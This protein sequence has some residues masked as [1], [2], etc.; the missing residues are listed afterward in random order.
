[1]K[2]FLILLFPLALS[3]KQDKCFPP[4]VKITSSS[5]LFEGDTLKLNASS[6]A[7][8]SF[9]WT[10]PNNFSSSLQAPFIPNANSINS[11][12]YRVTAKI[13]SCEKTETVNVNVLA[14]P[15]CTPQNNSTTF[16]SLMQFSGGVTCE[17]GT[18]AGTYELRGGGL[19]GN[20]LIKFFTDPHLKGNYVYDIS[21]MNTQSY[22]V[23]IEI[24]QQGVW[25][26]KAGKLYVSLNN[27][28]LTATF[29][30]IPFSDINIGLSK[31]GSGKLTC[32]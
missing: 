2:N 4:T 8:A 28:K 24:Y 32:P 30:S 22:N 11:G 29:C 18:S 6:V 19:Q 23:F 17:E 21:T 14:K 31:N 15:P 25:Q 7:G 9:V 27:N 13:G 1:M 10:G 3:C 5:S 16:F 12:E 20:I 26:A